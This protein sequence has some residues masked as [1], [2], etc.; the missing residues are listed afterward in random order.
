MNAFMRRYVGGETAFDPIMTGEVTLP[1]ADAPQQSGVAPAEEVKTSYVGPAAERFDVLQPLPAQDPATVPPAP[2][3]PNAL[4]ID[5]AGGAI[6]NSGF[7]QFL[8]CDPGGI[9][10]RG[11][12]SLPTAYP[13]CPLDTVT[14]PASP[15]SINRSIGTQFQLGWSAPATLSA[16][17]G[18]YGTIK[19][20]SGFGVLDLRASVNRMDPRNP[21]GNNSLPQ[22]ATQDFNVTLIDADGK[23]A[24]TNAAKWSTALEPSI[25]TSYKHVV[26]NGIRIP[27][28]AFTGIDLK[29]LTTVE[30]GF[31]D[32]H[33]ERLDPA[34]RRVRSRRTRRRPCARRHRASRAGRGRRDHPAARR[35]AL[36]AAGAGDRH[37]GAARRLAHQL[38]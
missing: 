5:A 29:R 24:T 35:P 32:A 26:L 17:L 4:T 23:R 15:A 20:V 33:H 7:E 27:L 8:V 13:L 11:Q 1:A 6:S 3:D 22:S 37:A 25:G 21:Q 28:S 18:P 9:P 30:F 10:L 16:K 19:D 2:V 34:R 38:P 12:P 36:G 31:G 14:N